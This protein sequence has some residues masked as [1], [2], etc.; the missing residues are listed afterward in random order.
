MTVMKSTNEASNPKDTYKT[1]VKTAQQLFMEF[2]Y[3]AVSTRQI[4]ELCAITQPALYHHFKNKQTLYIAVIQYTLLQNESALN[5]IVKQATTFSDRLNQMA[6]YMTVNY[7]MDLPQMFHDIVHEL[8]ENHQQEIHKCWVKGFLMPVVKM[9][10][11][12]ISQGEIKHVAL[13][14][15]SSTELA[16]IILN[17]IKA[18]LQPSRMAKNHSGQKREMEKKAKL[19]VEIFLNGVGI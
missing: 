5:Q 2:G 18:T 15:T 1:I 10:D 9:I 11:D 17:L 13:L 4:A 12:G 6:I 3:R 8:D 7:G 14:H 16:Y 19:V